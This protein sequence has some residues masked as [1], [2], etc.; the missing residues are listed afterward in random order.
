[1]SAAALDRLLAMLI[2]AQLVTGLV[3][4]R[5]GT[6]PT[7]LLFIVH[8][9][10]AGALLAAIGLKLWRSVPKAIRGRR[11]TA[12]G[13]SLALGV[14]ASAALVGGFAWVASGRIL[15]VGPWTILTLHVWAALVLVPIAIVHLVPRRWRVLRPT[16]SG[17]GIISRRSALTT[18]G[19]GVVGVIGWGAANAAE[20][21]LGAG[22]RFTGS[23]WRPDG[24]IPPSTT[25]FG[26]A[27]PEIDADAWRLSV[28]G[29]VDRPLS[30]SL[31]DLLAIGPVEREAVLD[32]TSGWALRTTWGGIPI[33]ALLEA[34]RAAGDARR[35]HVRSVTDWF[36]ELPIDEAR[37]ALLATAVAGR[38]LPAGNGAPCRLVAPGRR[39]LE[40]VKWVDRIEVS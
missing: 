15:L 40:W 3:S 35:V 20:R 31:S 17:A 27:A 32:C 26:E 24:G 21:L 23:R 25:F 5:A 11:W 36:A 8:G 30:L 1:M 29:R 22:R 19:L 39:G 6:P 12:L 2:V 34:A 4:L 7:A 33:A 13:V 37:N 38:P 16:G 18:I 28:T 9:L 14:A 10:L